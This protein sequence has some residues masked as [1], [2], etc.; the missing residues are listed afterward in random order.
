M[1]IL[2]K[3]LD[4]L[5]YTKNI[6]ADFQSTLMIGRQQYFGS[7]EYLN[8]FINKEIQLTD[9]YSEP[10][11]RQ[12]WAKKIDSIDYS[13]YEKAT[14]IHDMNLP[15]H[16][17]IKWKYT[18]IFD[19]GSQEHIFNF[20]QSIKNIIEMLQEGWWF[21]GILPTNNWAWHGF[22]QFSPELFYR[23]FSENNWCEILN[24][25]IRRANKDK[26]PWYEL[27]DPQILWKRCEFKSYAPLS[28][29]VI[30]KKNSSCAIFKKTPQ[31]SDYVTQW[32][33]WIP[34]FINKKRSYLPFKVARFLYKIFTRKK[35]F[36]SGIGFVESKLYWKITINKWGK[37]QK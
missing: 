29:A 3:D 33:K 27:K 14:I 11:F 1:G 20:P 4:I 31:Q 21:I 19:S 16:E 30:A 9:N 36:I 8:S 35:I 2:Q 22:Y 28:I 6:W 34:V 24:I 12:L 25:F 7:S 10:I 15:I 5:W 23:I 17:N 37:Y 26:S 32:Q 13:D 18:Y